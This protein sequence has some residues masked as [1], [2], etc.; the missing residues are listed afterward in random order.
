MVEISC[1]NHELETRTAV[2]SPEVEYVDFDLKQKPKA[3]YPLVLS[4]M[5]FASAALM[6]MMEVIYGLAH[7]S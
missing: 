4:F 5:K 6:K 3:G 1:V 7:G 2:I